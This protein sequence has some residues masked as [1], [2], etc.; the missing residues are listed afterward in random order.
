MSDWKNDRGEMEMRKHGEIMMKKAR[1]DSLLRN[2]LFV[3]D[4]FVKDATKD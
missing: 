3:I 1:E 2:I 4:L